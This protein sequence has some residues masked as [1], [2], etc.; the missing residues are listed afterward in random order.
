MSALSRQGQFILLMLLVA[1]C[2]PLSAAGEGGGRAL[3]IAN[4]QTGLRASLPLTGVTYLTIKFFHSYDRVW[5]EES[6]RPVEGN[7]YPCEVSYGAD[8]YDYRDQ[9]YVSRARVGAHQVHL[10][11]IKPR[12]SDV[13]AQI[14]TRVAFTKPQKLILHTTKESLVYL[15]TQWG[16]PGEPLVFRIK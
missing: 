9:R 7:L 16:R 13:L 1:L 15:F 3:L 8:T 12:P 14:A 5:I 2:L 10:T 6:F 4:P 11:D